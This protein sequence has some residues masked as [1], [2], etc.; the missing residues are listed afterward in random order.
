MRHVQPQR[1]PQGLTDTHSLAR[2]PGPTAP[3]HP[4]HP[5]THRTTEQ[6]LY[7]PEKMAEAKV[8][9]SE[10]FDDDSVVAGTDLFVEAECMGS[11]VTVYEHTPVVT[12]YFIKEKS[13]IDKLK[14]PNPETDGRMPF[15]CKE[16]E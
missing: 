6:C 8:A 4:P 16:I 15:V 3:I 10:K 7:D 11:K 13:D 12:E 14:V 1:R 5:S 9:S 2:C